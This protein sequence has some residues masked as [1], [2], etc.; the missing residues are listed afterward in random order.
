[1]NLRAALCTQAAMTW[2]CRGVRFEDLER[3]S[4]W[5][6]HTGS[7]GA[8]CVLGRWPP[9]A[10]CGRQEVWVGTVVYLVCTLLQ[11][12]RA[13]RRLVVI[14]GNGVDT[15]CTD[16][17]KGL[18]TC[19]YDLCHGQGERAWVVAVAYVEDTLLQACKG[20]RSPCRRRRGE[21]E[22]SSLEHVSHGPG[23]KCIL[24]DMMG[25]EARKSS[26]RCGASR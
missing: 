1:M 8:G 16:L 17:R 24:D 22:G 2:S 6:V 7:S 10:P 18:P 11:P 20:L 9:H 23:V 15:L 21:G 19:T 12:A 14:C 13:S 4:H 25:E 26:A 5:H 3:Q